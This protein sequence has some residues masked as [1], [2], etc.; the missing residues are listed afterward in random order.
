MAWFLHDGPIGIVI[1]AEKNQALL[2]MG[3]P[4]KLRKG[5]LAIIVS[6]TPE[7]VNHLFH[8]WR[9]RTV[10]GAAQAHSLHTRR[11]YSSDWPRGTVSVSHSFLA[12]MRAVSTI[13]PT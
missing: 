10:R 7:D 12:R 9:I 4:S 8:E 3:S 5:F 2:A 6:P 13:C 1:K 11:L